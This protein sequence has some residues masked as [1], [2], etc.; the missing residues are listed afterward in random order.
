MGQLEHDRNNRY[1]PEVFW[2]EQRRKKD[3]ENGSCTLREQ[4]FQETPECANTNFSIEASQD[5]LSNIKWFTSQAE[6]LGSQKALYW[7]ARK[8][9]ARFQALPS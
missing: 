6:N 1:Q 3:G 2:S 8:T 9:R 4:K 7:A 5:L